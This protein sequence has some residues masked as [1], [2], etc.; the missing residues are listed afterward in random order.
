MALFGELGIELEESSQSDIDQ[1]K[2]DLE[3]D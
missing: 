3:A 1:Q 2:V